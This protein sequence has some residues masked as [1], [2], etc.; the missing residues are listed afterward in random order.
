VP[1]FVKRYAELGT[2][3]ERAIKD[4]AKEVTEGTFPGKEHS[5][6]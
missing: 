1:K 6:E 4:F 3:M 5:Y 2:E